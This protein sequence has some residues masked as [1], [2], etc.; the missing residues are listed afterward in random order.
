[1]KKN[2]YCA[3]CGRNLNKDEVA[4]NKKLIS[5]E[6]TSF[7]CLMCLSVDMGCEVEDL[8]TKIEEYK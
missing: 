4:L 2:Y 8:E 6:L 7:Q 5:L 1:M 3:E